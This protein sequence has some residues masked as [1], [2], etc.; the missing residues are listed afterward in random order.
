M[1]DLLKILSDLENSQSNVEIALCARLG[2]PPEEC[3]LVKKGRITQLSVN[4]EKPKQTY[5]YIDYEEVGPGGA[6]RFK[7]HPHEIKKILDNQGK[8]VYSN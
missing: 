3:S 1:D 8:I 6:V 7:S 4:E 5:F 2:S